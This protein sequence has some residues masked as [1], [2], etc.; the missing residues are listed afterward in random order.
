MADMSRKI[1]FAID[2][3][4][5]V[6][7]SNGPVPL[8]LIKQLKEEGHFVFCHGNRK[9]CEEAQIP[10]AEGGTKEERLRLLREKVRADKYIVVDDVRIDVEG[11]EYLTPEEFVK[12]PYGK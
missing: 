9:L 2:R 12:N 1:C 4:G 7:T 11:W 10:Y 5:T 3:D 6:E 8:S